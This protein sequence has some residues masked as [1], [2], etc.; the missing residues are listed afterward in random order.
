MRMMYMQGGKTPL[1]CAQSVAVAKVLLEKGVDPNVKDYVCVFTR[2]CMCLYMCVY[3]FVHVGAC[4]RVCVT[5][6]HA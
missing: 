4:I 1:H 3:V 2:V 5:D 6:F